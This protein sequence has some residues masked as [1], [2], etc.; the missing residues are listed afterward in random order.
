MF[1]AMNEAFWGLT[2]VEQFQ[3]VSRTPADYE[4]AETLAPPVPFSAILA[5]LKTQRLLIKPEGER[6][7]KWFQMYTTQELMLADVVQAHDGKTYR[8][9]SKDDWNQAGY[10]SYELTEGPNVS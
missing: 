1:P 8:V 2:S 10:F 9:M 3:K 4:A 5:P 7:W 6:R